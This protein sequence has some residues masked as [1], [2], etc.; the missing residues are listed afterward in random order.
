M[1]P[2]P[3]SIRDELL[4]TVKLAAPLAGAN[5]AQMVMGLTNAIMVGRLGGA[6]LAAAGLG[7]ALYFTLVMI[8]QGILTAVAPL[9]AHAIGAGD[10]AA[11][12]RVGGAGMILAGLLAVPVLVLLSLA[13]ALLGVLGYDDALAAE[14]A[15]FVGAISWGAPAFLGFVVLRSL[16]SARSRVRP[17]TVVLVLGV[18]TNALLNWGLI[19]GH[20]GLPAL[21][22]VGSGCAT[23][24]V[25]WLM[26]LSL[27]G[28]TLLG[29]GTVRLK[30]DVNSLRRLGAIVRLGLPISGLM[31]L[32]VGLFN[33]TGV[34]MGTLGGDALG[35]HQLAINFASLTFMVPLGIAQA[36]TVRVAL[37]LGSDDP[38]AAR[39]A[40]FVALVLGGLLMLIPCGVMLLVPRPI[41]GIYLD[42]GDPA[43]RGTAALAVELLAIAAFFQVFDGVQVIA[44]GALR[45]YRDTAL[46]MAFA[47]AGYWGVGF[48]SGWM[49]AFP[50][51]YGAIGLWWG[52]AL[53]LAT[54]AVLLA[55]RLAYRS[56]ALP[57]AVPTDPAPVT[58]WDDALTPAP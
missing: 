5:L 57:G 33:A 32:D 40:G 35:A 26:L 37:Q 52:Q 11:A 38:A 3:L 43:N 17:I 50:L 27:A 34:L 9:A 16:L 23:A 44:A 48:A 36:A 29:P 47:A 7:G 19:F 6:S 39:R 45:G 14:I 18:P 30:F 31:A 24:I 46:P 49:L 53:G 12:E 56:R 22:I 58:R 10:R 51:G 13:P 28:Y 15:R 41:V 8:C 21:G 54:V 42:L 2:H 55:L 20:L 1:P 25:Q 4:A